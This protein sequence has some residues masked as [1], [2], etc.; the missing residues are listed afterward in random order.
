[1]QHP[2]AAFRKY[3]HVVT[4]VTKDNNKQDIFIKAPHHAKTSCLLCVVLFRKPIQLFSPGLPDTTMATPATQ[5]PGIANKPAQQV[6]DNRIS[7]SNSVLILLDHQV[8]SGHLLGV[9]GKNPVCC[10]HVAAQAVK[11]SRPA[12]PGPRAPRVYNHNSQHK[13]VLCYGEASP[14]V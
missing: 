10:H 8:R 11:P 3:S 5:T 4:K 12:H 2:S 7:A 1:M 14:I 13:Q 6:K 9:P